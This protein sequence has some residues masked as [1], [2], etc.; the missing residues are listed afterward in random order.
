MT[1]TATP[2]STELA[3]FQQGDLD[4]AV[5]RVFAA[6]WRE[7][8]RLAMTAV[9][10]KTITHKRERVNGTW[11]DVAQPPE[12]IKATVFAVIR[13]GAE[14]F[15]YPGPVAL[16]KVDVIEGRLEP[17]Y[18]AL[19]GR[20]LDAGHQ[21]R[22]VEMS[23]T[24]AALRVRR[25][26]EI[27]DPDAWQTFEFTLDEAKAAGYVRDNPD[28]RDRKGAWYTRRADMLMS[29]AARRA[30]RLAASDTLVQRDAI[31]ILDG[32]SIDQLTAPAR[33]AGVI[34]AHSSPAPASQLADVDPDDEPIDVEIVEEPFPDLPPVRE[35]EPSAPAEPSS[36]D[37]PVDTEAAAEH[38][39][40]LQRQLMATATQAFPKDTT[41]PPAQQRAKVTAQRHAV[42]YVAL[43][44]HKSANDMTPEEL[45]RVTA[46]LDD[47]IQRR[48]EVE[49]RDGIWV[50]IQGDREIEIPAEDV[51]A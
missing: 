6:Q 30:F 29:K 28:D 48:L 33:A 50:A 17:R 10:P 37:T 21:V 31:E 46:R 27:N 1:D 25:A 43:G 4:P 16:G 20:M 3:V 24:R 5:A 42:A 11:T 22:T 39:A 44:E 14:V 35:P 7:A 12:V 15:G 23:A 49:E 34:D 40:K 2:P 38:R 13:Y 45:T 32:A 26:D 8:Q 47:V 36:S 51:A 18:D 19:M 9:I 41:L